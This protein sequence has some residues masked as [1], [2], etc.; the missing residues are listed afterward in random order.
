[1]IVILGEKMRALAQVL[2]IC[3]ALAALTQD[4]AAQSQALPQDVAL[5]IEEAIRVSD[6]AAANAA[7]S[8]NIANNGRQTG[9]ADRTRLFIAQA[10]LAEAVVEGC[11]SNGCEY[12]TGGTAV[13]LGPVGDNFG[14]GMT[15]GMAFVYDS[16]D[17]FSHRVNTE[18]LVFQRIETEYWENRAKA[19]VLEHVENTQSRFAERLLNDWRR[20]VVKFWQVV[21]KEMLDLLDQPVTAKDTKQ[22][23]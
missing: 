5:A 16:D 3:G 19:L 17:T 1:M 20:Q 9:I 4:A 14:A 13:I 6:M 22:R 12:M 18:T 15:G 21:P 2:V 23:A 7:F 11:G 8:A 10:S